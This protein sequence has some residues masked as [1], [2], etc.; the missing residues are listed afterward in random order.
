MKHQMVRLALI[1]GILFL[2]VDSSS[3]RYYDA[4]TG[5]FLQIDPK[6]HKFSGWSPYNYALNNPLKYIDPDGQEVRFAN[7]TS[8]VFQKQFGA[9]VQYLNKRGASGM[10]RQ[11]HESTTVYYI[12]EGNGH[13]NYDNKTRTINWDPSMGVVTNENHI[14]SPTTV[15]NHEVDHAL[16]HDQNPDQF[17]NDRKTPDAQYDTK[18]EKR[19]IEGTEQE[20]AKKLGEIKEGEV[21]RLDHKG[22][23]FKS[24]GPTTT[25]PQ[26]VIIVTPKREDEK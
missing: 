13:T 18:E 14:L 4:R 23:K 10:L 16:Q 22:S 3:A 26:N 8:S 9:A 6:A 5:R 25:E 17:N 7:G 21:T 15:L 2:S 24:T 20:T 11:L 12:N 1:A 19:V